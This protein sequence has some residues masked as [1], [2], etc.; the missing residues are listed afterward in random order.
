MSQHAHSAKPVSA[1]R[2]ET[3]HFV[4]PPDVNYLGKLAGGTLMH[5]MDLTAA[6]AAGRH[7][8]AVAV[9]ASV[10]SLDFK[11]PANLGEVVII[12]ASVNR[13]FNS[14]MEVGVKVISENLITGE[15]KVCNRAYFTFVAIDDS[16]S[17]TPVPA[18]T[19]ETEAE[20]KRYEKAE[21]R[22]QIRL[23]NK[24]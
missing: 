17:P 10:D 9:T 6:I 1:S 13:A 3:T 24:G 15:Q 23:L 22:R 14:S 7:A 18:I 5:W 12:K 16:L 4:T 19:P 8:N 21:L 11:H 20:K 2:V